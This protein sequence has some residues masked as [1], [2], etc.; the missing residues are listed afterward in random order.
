MRTRYPFSLSLL[1]AAIMA[2]RVH[3]LVTQHGTEHVGCSGWSEALTE[4]VNDPAR[5]SGE[6]GPLAPSAHF[7]YRGDLAAFE[8]VLA[9]YAALSKQPHT[10]YLE[11]GIDRGD[12]FDLSI[13]HEG[14]GFLHFNAAGRIPLEQLKIP[15]GVAVEALPGVAEPVDPQEKARVLEQRKRV[16]DFVAAHKELTTVAAAAAFT[17]GTPAPPINAIGPDGNAFFPEHIKGK[18]MLLVFWSLH[19]PASIRQ[20]GV[21]ENLRREF[22]GQPLQI[23]SLCTDDDW[24]AWQRVMLDQGSLDFGQGPKPFNSDPQWWQLIQAPRAPNTAAAYGVT[25]TPAAF[26]IGL[27]G[28][29]GAVQIPSEKVRDIVNDALRSVRTR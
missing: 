29:L 14:H 9:K 15:A 18:M 27:D 23:I 7:H 17:P 26:L 16:A 1:L 3:A 10:L 6:V 8:R 5:V 28:R 13:T 12:D 20:F 2:P 19:E 11:A 21:L 25:K 22:A 24:D 4:I